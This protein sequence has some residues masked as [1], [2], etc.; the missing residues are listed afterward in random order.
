MNA[1]IGV[2]LHSGLVHMVVGTSANVADVMQASALLHGAEQIVLGDAGYQGVGKRPENVERQVDWHIPMRQS[3]RDK[4]SKDLARAQK[5][6]DHMRSSLRARVEHPF[7]VIKRQSGYA[8]VRYRRLA[9]NTAQLR[10]LFMLGNLWMARR[11]VLA[12][13]GAVCPQW[14]KNPG[15]G[16]KMP[17][18][19]PS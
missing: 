10:T 12:A 3:A 14:A 18:W 16:A 1:H 6:L 4:L 13:K 7:R 5:Q 15:N 9:K 11:H 19:R 17:R 2:D 8:I